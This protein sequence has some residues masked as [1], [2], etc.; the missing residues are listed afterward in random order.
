MKLLTLLTIMAFCQILTCQSA[1]SDTQ[2][3]AGLIVT[4]KPAKRSWGNRIRGW[5]QS[6]KRRARNA[7]RR[8][9]RG[10]KTPFQRITALVERIKKATEPRK[11][12]LINIL[13]RLLQRLKQRM[14][15]ADFS[16][17]REDLKA[18]TDLW[19]IQGV[20]DILGVAPTAMKMH[21]KHK[22]HKKH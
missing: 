5:G 14:T 13:L 10:R 7:W 19:A 3:Q 16:K 11:A 12:R 9:R 4:G 20:T 22:K 17:L 8:I 6:M 18:N 1:P 2:Y 21:K 15:A